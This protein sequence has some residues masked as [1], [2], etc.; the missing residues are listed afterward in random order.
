MW[1]KMGRIFVPHTDL[2]WNKSHA[3]LPTALQ[4][5]KTRY[6]IFISGRDGVNRSLIGYFDI[7]LKN[8][9]KILHVSKKPV[10][11]LG[12]LGCFDDNGV[13][14][15]SIIR[16]GDRLYLYYIGWRPR[17]TTRMSLIAGLAVSDD[18]GHT[19]KRQSKA[20]L[21]SLTDRE[22]YSILTAP[23][24]IH[25]K[26]DWKMWYVSGE[27]WI[28]EDLPVYNI[29][30]AS[31]RDGIVWQREG[32][33][34]LDFASEDEVALARPCVL[35][36][37]GTYK[38]WFSF[39]TKTNTYRIGYAESLSGFDFIRKTNQIKGLEPSPSGWDSEMV[40]YPCVIKHA[41]NLFMFYN[42]NNYGSNGVGLAVLEAGCG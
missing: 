4:L 7:D 21:L 5:E 14:P 24:V 42:G 34:A 41:E 16:N 29:K 17:S 31:S 35:Y 40:E 8:P 11:E 2:S 6:R 3:M 32:R 1:H 26:S 18:N 9:K 12:K 27:G 38:M 25:T 33:V 28:H 10:L 15:A 20:P 30:F 19:F 39:K 23:W 13:T 37:D 22:P 36:E